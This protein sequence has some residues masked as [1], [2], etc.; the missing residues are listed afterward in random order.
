MAGNTGM[1]SNAIKWAAY[2][3]RLLGS[4]VSQTC[5]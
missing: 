4:E 5:L 1:L 2:N 3:S